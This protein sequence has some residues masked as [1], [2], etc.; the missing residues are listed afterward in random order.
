MSS[1]ASAMTLVG[2]DPLRD[3]SYQSTRLGRDVADFLAW[4]ELGG[5]SPRTLDQYERDLARGALMFP[6]KGATEIED[7]D[8][9]HIA[10]QFKPGERRV[11]IAAYR[12]FYKFLKKSR[13]VTADPTEA[14]PEF[15][16]PHP[17][18]YDIFSEAE[19]ALMVRLPSPDGT[20]MA[21]LLDCGLRM[22]EA[23]ALE[24]RHFRPDPTEAMPW[25]ALVVKGKGRKERLIRCTERMA[26]GIAT[27]HITEGLADS[28]PLWYGHRS[29]DV[30][31]NVYRPRGGVGEGTFKRW[32]RD[33]LKRAG[34]RYRNPHMARHTFAT[35]WLQ[36]GGR[37][38]R[39]SKAMGHASIRTT[40]DLYV[41]LDYGDV[42]QD[43]AL[44]E[45]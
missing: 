21:I 16:R 37:V 20:L 5:A 44:I 33:N 36:A 2:F 4:L 32:W 45:E 40:L 1:P 25:G 27:M 3:K 8:M 42:A 43:L 26:S 13:R 9:L 11:R 22:G 17:K 35:R 6:E 29:N 38:E 41:H 7:G 18:V 28:S 10:R 19:R 24:L 31:R 15:T 39:L 34:V 23:R 12:S 14:L 30:V